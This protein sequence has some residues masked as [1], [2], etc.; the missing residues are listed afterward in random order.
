MYCKY[1]IE[2]IIYLQI[3]SAKVE[4]RFIWR[5]KGLSLRER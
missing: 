1:V 3:F 2:E 5:Q 4:I